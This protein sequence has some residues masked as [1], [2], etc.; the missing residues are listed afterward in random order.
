MSVVVDA[1]V[2]ASAVLGHHPARRA[3]AAAGTVHCPAHMA[4]EAFSALCRLRRTSAIDSE[5]FNRAIKLLV[6]FPV[7]THPINNLIEP[8]TKMLANITAKDALYI[9]LAIELGYRVLTE[10][11]RLTRATPVAYATSSS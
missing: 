10:D 6:A 7:A 8:A 5:T 3:I 9:A 11:L 1:S 4:A 2:V